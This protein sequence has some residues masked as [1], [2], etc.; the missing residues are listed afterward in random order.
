MME[1]LFFVAQTSLCYLGG[2]KTPVTACTWLT[3]DTVRHGKWLSMVTT[4]CDIWPN[5]FHGIYYLGKIFQEKSSM[6]DVYV[7]FV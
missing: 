4:P 1:L 2:T 3:T 6:P 5:G 7:K